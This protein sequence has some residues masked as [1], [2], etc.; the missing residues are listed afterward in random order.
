MTTDTP[1]ARG[2]ILFTIRL[3]LVVVAAL[4]LFRGAQAGFHWTASRSR[5]LVEPSASRTLLAAPWLLAEDVEGMRAGSFLPETPVSFFDAGL[6]KDLEGSYARSPWVKRVVTVHPVWPNRARVF[7]EIRR[8]VAGILVGGAEIHLVDERGVRLPGIRRTPPEGLRKPFLR[9][10]GVRERPPRAGEVWSRAVREG[11]AVVM[12]LGTLREDVAR[13]ARIQT[14]DVSN[15]GGLVDPL[16]PEILL[17]TASGAVI[18]WGRSPASP[19]AVTERTLEEK[20]LHLHRALLLYPGLGG[21]SR[22]KVQFDR[23]TVEEAASGEGANG[24]AEAR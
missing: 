16:E 15:V 7:L 11:V 13:A 9:L 1:A 19:R 14:V 17:G 24:H 20:V 4:L 18:E 6:L 21:L 22:L 5:F 3:L 12:D 8:P 23:L 10:M 2:R